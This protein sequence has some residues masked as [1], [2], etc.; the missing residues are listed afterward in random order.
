MVELRLCLKLLSTTATNAEIYLQQ[1]PEILAR[2]KGSSVTTTVE[3]TRKPPTKSVSMIDVGGG[4]TSKSNNMLQPKDK[5][6]FL[7]HEENSRPAR[8]IVS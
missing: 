5:T 4:G 6:I 8:K 7:G 1:N 2:L 3:R